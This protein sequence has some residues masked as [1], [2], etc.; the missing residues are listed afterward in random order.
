MKR[1]SKLGKLLAYASE[2][3]RPPER[4]AAIEWMQKHVPTPSSHRS[5]TYDLDKSAFMVPV[6]QAVTEEGCSEVHCMMGV[7]MGKSETF[8]A[9]ASWLLAHRSFAT[10]MVAQT[11][12][13]SQIFVET[14]LMPSLLL[15]EQ[16]KP[17]LPTRARDIQKKK[18]LFPN[19]KPLHF[20]SATM[21][22]LQ[23][24]SLDAVFLDEIWLYD[25][26]LLEEARRRTHDRANSIVFSAS[27]A[28]IEGDQLDRAFHDSLSHVWGYKCPACGYEQR[29]N[30]GQ[31]RWDLDEA[32]GKDGAIN[33]TTLN[34]TIRYECINGDCNHE[35]RDTPQ[36]RY[37]MNNIQGRYLC[38]NNEGAKPGRKSFRASAVAACWIPWSKL[39]GEWLTAIRDLK[40]DGNRES[41]RIFIQKRLAESYAEEEVAIKFENNHGE[42]YNLED[43]K[44]GKPYNVEGFQERGRFLCIDVQQDHFH[45]A[46]YAFS[47]EANL[48]LVDIGRCETWGSL[49]S[50]QRANKVQNRFVLIDRGYKTAEV[51][52]QAKK[53]QSESPMDRDRWVPMAGS[54]AKG[55]A[56]KINKGGKTYLNAVS[57]KHNSAQGCNHTYRNHSNIMIKDDVESMLNGNTINTL[58]IPMDA[59]KDYIESITKSETRKR[60]KGVWTWVK[61]PGKVGDNNHQ[62]DCLCLAVAGLCLYQVKRIISEGDK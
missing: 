61:S 5:P 62:F 32:R 60:V 43:Y 10:M 7:G 20:G 16:V 18:I 3:I 22:T 54:S 53:A 13:E 15:N 57:Q 28:G 58:R 4:L 40:H 19:G 33:W 39:V 48:A 41:K 27:Q 49:F 31:M 21:S 36:D 23:S 51:A 55:F 56:I 38:D 50:V 14:R 25:E 17:L 34:D 6:L 12:A 46:C 30:W 52:V 35:Y 29:H 11:Q 8:I 2:I 44:D 9:S 42:P 47:A 1:Q 26:G 37:E 59:P 45:F 24:K